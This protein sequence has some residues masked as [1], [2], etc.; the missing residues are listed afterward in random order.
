MPHGGKL[1]IQ[2]LF[3]KEAKEVVVELKDTGCGIPKE[4]QTR[5]F[6]PFFT[7]KDPGKGTGLGLSISYRIVKENNGH[8]EVDSEVG[9]GSNFRIRFPAATT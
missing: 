7:T 3:D 1:I 9:K 2:T 4:I 8:I 5:I 6:E